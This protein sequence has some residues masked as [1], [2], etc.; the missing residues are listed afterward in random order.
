MGARRARVHAAIG[1]LSL[2]V[3]AAPS[4]ASDA[5]ET[6]GLAVAASWGYESPTFGGQVDYY[7]LPAGTP[8]HFAGYV[9]AGWFPPQNSNLV[10][11][12]AT[13]GF[14]GG[15]MAF[16]GHR[17]R[18]LVDVSYG[19]SGWEIASRGNVILRQD[20]LNGVTAAMGYEYVSSG[21]F[22]FRT[23]VGLNVLTGAAFVS[24]ISRLSLTSLLAVGWKIF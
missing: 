13:L 23:T 17:H 8:F 6:S 21:G 22:L 18:G 5:A 7:W 19:L 14:A 9:G 3:F 24:G 4:R 11:T 16:V 12:D 20:K 10:Q 1:V 15:A 2:G